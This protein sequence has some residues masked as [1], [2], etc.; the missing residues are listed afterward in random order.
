[1]K[2]CE[3]REDFQFRRIYRDLSAPFDQ[4][5][6]FAESVLCLHQKWDRNAA[7]VQGPF[8]ND[9]ALCDEHGILRV[10]SVLQLV[11]SEPCVDIQRGIIKTVYRDKI[12][13]CT[14][15]GIFP[16]IP[17]PFQ[18]RNRPAFQAR[19]W[20]WKLQ[21]PFRRVFPSQDKAKSRYL[22]AHPEMFSDR[23]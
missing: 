22:W 15:C 6:A 21:A 10:F 19:I 2:T 23:H 3:F 18:G 20:D 8:N 12:H 5:S 13:K 11:F 9:G 4:N 17:L 1:M 7:G 16:C 14:V